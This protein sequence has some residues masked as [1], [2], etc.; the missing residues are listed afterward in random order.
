VTFITDAADSVSHGAGVSTLK[1]KGGRTI[2]ATF[3]MDGTG[4]ARRLVR[5]AF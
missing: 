5:G 1:L 4:H 3:V 2:Q